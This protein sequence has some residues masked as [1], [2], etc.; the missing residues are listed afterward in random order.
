MK[1]FFVHL[2]YEFHAGVR[3]KSLLFMLY[4]FPLLLYLLLG[5]LMAAMNPT[6][7]ESMIPSMCTIAILTAT[8]MTLPG[9]L[10]VAC[11]TGIL[12]SY[13][14]NGI[15]AASILLIPTLAAFCH[16]IV[17]GTIITVTA[18]ILFGAP[19]PVNWPYFILIS[20]LMF[21]TSAG[22]GMLIAIIST[23]TQMVMLLVQ[24]IFVPAMMLGGLMFPHAGLPKTLG[25]IA[26][27]LPTTYSMNAMRSLV[28][29]QPVD[30]NV[31]WSIIILLV[32][33]VL[34]FGLSLYLFKWDIHEY[35]KLRSTSMALIAVLP[36]VA[37]MLL[38]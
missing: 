34:S 37:G 5:S 8:M 22:I 19:L 11:E 23:S 15:S 13:K 14:I 12:R 9:P 16:F 6:F 10:E 28:L 21:L 4:L 2:A 33:G 36:Y 27:L 3:N 7:R 29:D 26:M 32:S 38:L 24:I 25:K 35:N 18:P 31:S 30:L 1:A 20:L 17:M